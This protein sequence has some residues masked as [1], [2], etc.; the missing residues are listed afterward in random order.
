MFLLGVLTSHSRLEHCSSMLEKNF[1]LINNTR[2]LNDRLHARA[3]LEHARKIGCS[4]MARLKTARKFLA[5]TRS[6]HKNFGLLTTQKLLM[7]YCMLE[8]CSNVLE[9]L[10]ARKWLCSKPLKNFWLELARA[11]KI[12]A[13]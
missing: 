7:I 2:A 8:H 12:L 5:R 11:M 4:K 10:A 13:C 3:L 6:S 1:W 9:K